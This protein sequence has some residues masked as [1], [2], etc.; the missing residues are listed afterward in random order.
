MS[1]YMFVLLIQFNT[2]MFIIN[3]KLNNLYYINQL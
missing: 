3:N 1:N 2:D